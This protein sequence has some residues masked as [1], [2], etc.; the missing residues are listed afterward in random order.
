MCHLAFAVPCCEK[1]DEVFDFRRSVGRQLL[2]LV[3]ERATCWLRHVRIVPRRSAEAW[4]PGLRGLAR[5]LCPARLASAA[6]R[7]LLTLYSDSPQEF[8][9]W[10]VVWILG[11]DFTVEGVTQNGLTES[12]RRAELRTDL[13]FN[14][15]DD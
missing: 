13:R 1:V 15:I 11:H 14:V 7:P 5:G 6:E 10:F 9:C 2:D 3:D 12:T 8:R 4:R